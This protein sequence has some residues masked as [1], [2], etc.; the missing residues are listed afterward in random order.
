MLTSSLGELQS[1]RGILLYTRPWWELLCWL[2]ISWIVRQLL[3]I[4]ISFSRSSVTSSHF[5]ARRISSFSE[6]SNFCRTGGD[7]E[8]F[9]VY[10]YKKLKRNFP[11]Q[12]KNNKKNKFSFTSSSCGSLVGTGMCWSRH[13]GS[14]GVKIFPFSSNDN[15]SCRLIH[16]TWLCFLFSSVR[17]VRTAPMACRKNDQD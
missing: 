8:S 1:G 4:F 5:W 15:S 13:E 17:W 3:N 16:K 9:C 10:I 12:K 2:K 14:L 6:V 7:T 11:K